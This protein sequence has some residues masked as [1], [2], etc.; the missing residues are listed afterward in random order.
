[1]IPSC[2][3]LKPLAVRN[4]R[5]CAASWVGVWIRKFIYANYALKRINSH[6]YLESIFR[7]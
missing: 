1:L 6:Y 4:E 2:I 3:W 7:C 5:R